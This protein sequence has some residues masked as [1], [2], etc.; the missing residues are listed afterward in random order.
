MNA[1]EAASARLIADLIVQSRTAADAAGKRRPEEPI[2]AAGPAPTQAAAAGDIA[3]V[4][5]LG[6][7]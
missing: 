1:P 2:V 7:N 6:Y 3:G 4:A 5:V